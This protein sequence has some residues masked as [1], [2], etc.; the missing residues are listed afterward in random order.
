LAQPL[1]DS[2]L[3]GPHAIGGLAVRRGGI[4]ALAIDNLKKQP[5]SDREL[6]N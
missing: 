5:P 6:V 2:L 1:S 4:D 3:S